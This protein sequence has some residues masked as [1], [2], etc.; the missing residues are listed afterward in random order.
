M[1]QND[2]VRRLR[3][4]CSSQRDV[5]HVSAPA[6]IESNVET[7][8]EP[9]PHT[10]YF[11]NRDRGRWGDLIGNLNP[12]PVETFSDRQVIA[13]DIWMVQTYVQLR[14]RGLDVQLVDKIM[15]GAIN[16][17]TY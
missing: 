12:P 3:P 8:L 1:H 16:L 5:I 6:A 7:P 14:R 15:P 10:V 11:L 13:K 2:D 4:S 9:L 17:C